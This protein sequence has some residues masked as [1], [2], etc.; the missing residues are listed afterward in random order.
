MTS[1]LHD[2]NSMLKTP[3]WAFLLA[4]VT[5]NCARGHGTPIRVDVLDNRLV[6]SH[7]LGPGQF[8]P[9]VF[10]EADEEGDFFTVASL[11]GLGSTILWQ[12]P[13]LEIF[14]MSSTSTLSIEVLA[15]P[16]VDSTPTEHRVLWY[17]DPVTEEAG[18]SPAPFHLLGTGMRSLT[19]QPTAQTPP[20]PFRLANSMAGQTGFHNHGLLSYG[21]DDD[22]SAPAGV[23]G[24]FA[25]L[26]SNQYAPSD[27]F[28]LVFNYATDYDSSIPASL[29]IFHSGTLAGDFDLDDDVDG[30]DFLVWQRLFGS[31]TRT[32][33]DASLNGI[34]DA[35]D[36]EIWQQNYGD[37]FS[38]LTIAAV[39]LPE[40]SSLAL[41]SALA[42]AMLRSHRFVRQSKAN[43]SALHESFAKS[44]RVFV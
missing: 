8:A 39:S 24:F 20:S 19:L 10:G 14:G 29:E 12:L 17:W 41:L 6:A 33:A 32:V 21:L 2:L 27:P 35:P 40:P 25:R 23:Y 37:D 44:R 18:A 26:T 13:G 43:S 36:L 3:C 16:V 34:V 28:L 5:A 7:P 11:P 38:A 42:F 30:R 4:C 22:N 31:T 15:R 9:P 1:T